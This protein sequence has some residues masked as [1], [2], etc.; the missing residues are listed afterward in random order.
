M[1]AVEAAVNR[2]LDQAEDTPEGSDW[3]C[4]NLEKADWA[5]K[6][7]GE[8]YEEVAVNEAIA[9]KHIWSVTERLKRV[10]APLT[11]SVEFFRSVL[12]EFAESH[13][14]E[15]VRGKKKTRELI[16]GKLSFRTKPGRLKVVD[17]AALLAWARARPVEE[18]L[19]RIKEEVC[20]REVQEHAEKEQF[21]PP[22]MEWE[23]ESQSIEV[24]TTGGAK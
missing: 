6:R 22:G 15:I 21:L 3:K 20:L 13:R 1:S 8:I 24:K 18:G 17:D 5:L 4:D 9:E 2:L 12:V 11:K 16:H 7:L 19:V 23:P 10:N 14:D